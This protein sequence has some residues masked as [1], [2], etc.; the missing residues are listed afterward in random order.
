[1]KLIHF[2]AIEFN[3]INI[4]QFIYSVYSDGH[5]FVV[6][7]YYKYKTA[8]ANNATVIWCICACISLGIYLEMKLLGCWAC[9]HRYAKMK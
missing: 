8:I 9:I 4:I 2:I 5:L 6:W 3:W 7:D 1:M